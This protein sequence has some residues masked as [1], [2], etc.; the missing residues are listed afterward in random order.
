MILLDD[1]STT[2]RL[3]PPSIPVQVSA[4]VDSSNPEPAD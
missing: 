2:V 1:L 4:V 3:S